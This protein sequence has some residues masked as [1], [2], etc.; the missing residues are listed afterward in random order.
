MD[1]YQPSTR[2]TRIGVIAALCFTVFAISPAFAQTDSSSNC[3]YPQRASRSAARMG[4]F[5]RMGF[6]ARIV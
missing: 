3:N 4:K 6:L 5:Y 2:D 1:Q